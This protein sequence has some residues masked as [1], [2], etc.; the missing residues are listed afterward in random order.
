MEL[1]NRARRVGLKSG[2]LALED[3]A[4]AVILVAQVDVDGVDADRPGRDDRA[5]EK[6]VRIALEVVAILE[7]ARLAFVDV[8][9]HQARRRFGGH[10]LPLA[11]GGEAGAAKAAQPGVFHQRDDVGLLTLAAEHDAASA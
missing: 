7:R 1:G 4:A 8:D 10:E 6:P 11:A 2:E 3:G 9:R 5:F